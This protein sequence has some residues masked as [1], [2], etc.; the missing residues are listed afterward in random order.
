MHEDEWLKV[1]EPS[2]SR[3]PWGLSLHPISLPHALVMV[4]FPTGWVRVRLVVPL[5]SRKSCLHHD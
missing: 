4:L 5:R 1:G 3:L 2:G